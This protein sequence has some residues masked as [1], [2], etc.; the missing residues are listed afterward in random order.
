MVL[1]TDYNLVRLPMGNNIVTNQLQEKVWPDH[2]SHNS[3]AEANCFTT[4]EIPI[5]QTH[6]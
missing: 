5:A 1:N 3:Y 6:D 4:S 2:I